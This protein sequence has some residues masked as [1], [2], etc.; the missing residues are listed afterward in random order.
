MNHAAKSHAGKVRDENQDAVTAEPDIG[1]FVVADGMGGHRYGAQASR[2]AV[3][4]ISQEVRKA[5][6]E[7]K[8]D[9]SDPASR[10]RILE[11]A[12]NSAH[13]E[14]MK[15]ADLHSTRG[16]PVGTTATA[17]WCIDDHAAICHVGDSRL[18][19]LR[20]NE[21]TQLTTDH[22]VAQE[23]LEMGRITKEEVENSPYANIL[24]KALGIAERYATESSWE[25]ILPQDVFLLCSDGL[26]KL[27]PDHELEALLCEIRQHAIDGLADKLLDLALERGG[28]DNISLILVEPDI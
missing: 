11:N 10:A 22:T 9:F 26:N 24:S 21:F 3:S 5:L 8:N 18:Y 7:P 4:V 25:Q 14:I 16:E 28:P 15:F 27:I 12:F 13:H 17:I 19:R 1:L 20:E 23:V 2:L 6:E